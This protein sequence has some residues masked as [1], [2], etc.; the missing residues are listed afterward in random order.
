MQT[1]FEVENLKL[2]SDTHSLTLLTHSCIVLNFHSV[3]R[4]A[5]HAQSKVVHKQGAI[6]A[7]QDSFNDVVNLDAE[8]GWR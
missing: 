1:V 8:Q 4:L 7:I 5:A 6:R 2:F 3:Q